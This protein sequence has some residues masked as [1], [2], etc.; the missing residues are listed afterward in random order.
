MS[1]AWSPASVCEALDITP[2][3]LADIFRRAARYELRVLA[4]EAVSEVQPSAISMERATH[5]LMLADVFE[6]EYGRLREERGGA[7]ATQSE[8]TKGGSHSS[9]EVSA[10]AQGQA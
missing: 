3:E 2:E 9:D 1:S 10:A 6:T 7:D 5:M 8:R 4:E